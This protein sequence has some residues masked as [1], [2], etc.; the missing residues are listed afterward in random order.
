MED[1]TVGGIPCF[2]WTI[3]KYLPENKQ[4]R[5][6]SYRIQMFLLTYVTYSLFNMARRPIAVVKSKIIEECTGAQSVNNSEDGSEGWCNETFL[7]SSTQE[8][9]GLM[10]F[11]YVFSYGVRNITL[12]YSKIKSKL[13]ISHTI[14]T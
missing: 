8:I 2:T 12:F 6:F 13:S 14:E 4:K 5:E 9:M 11:V 7:V 3:R 1:T 10:D